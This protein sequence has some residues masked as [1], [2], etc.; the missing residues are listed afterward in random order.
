MSFQINSLVPELWCSDFQTSLDFY[1]TVLG[2][3]VAQRRANDKHAYLSLQGSQIMIAWWEQDGSWEPWIPE[4]NEPPYG[5]GINL[6]FLV[7]NVRDIHDAVTRA[8]VQPFLPMYTSSVWRTDRMDERTQFMVLDPDGYLL[9][10]SQVDSDR[11]IVASDIE[12][13]ERIH[14]K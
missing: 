6:Q 8:G 11:P 2:F 7:N 10:F 5:R 13:L 1:T 3:E 14:S 12:K 9:R 4:T